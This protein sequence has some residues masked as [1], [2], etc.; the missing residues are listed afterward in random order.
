MNATTIDIET[1]LADI[2]KRREVTIRNIVATRGCPEFIAGI[3]YDS[4]FAPLSTNAKMLVMIGVD[5][6]T[7]HA[8]LSD[9]AVANR[10]RAILEGLAKWGVY[11]TS[12]DH[13][14]DRG[15]MDVLSSILSEEAR[16][17]APDNRAEFI[18]LMC[19]KSQTPVTDRDSGLPRPRP[20]R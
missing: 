13:L 9:E 17:T 16:L 8:D 18:D 15:V 4:E 2:R 20:R 1:V 12:T 6:D 14:T 3:I 7:N 5:P 19:G 11:L 10:L